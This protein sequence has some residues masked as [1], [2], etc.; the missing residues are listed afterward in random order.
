LDIDAM[1]DDFV[2]FFVAG[3]ETTANTLAFCFLELGRNPSLIDKAREEIDRVLG[4][5]TVVSFQDVNEL[6]YC[7]AIFKE[8]LRLFPPVSSLAR[9][10]QKKMEIN[11]YA[12]PEQTF[13][14]VFFQDAYA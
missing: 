10:T 12:I 1:T 11:S 4:Q 2:T 7:A 13:L 6:K 14:L 5:R 3:Q 8:A 9:V